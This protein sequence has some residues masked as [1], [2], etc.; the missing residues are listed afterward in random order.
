MADQPNVEQ[1]PNAAP[2]A[3]ANAGV[4]PPLSA[5]PIASLDS[6][7]DEPA[8]APAP[9]EVQQ[10]AP[11]VPEPTPEP[12]A[13]VADA[14]TDEPA[15]EPE[16]TPEPTARVLP[17]RISTQQFSE[18]EQ[19][20]IALGKALKEAGEDVPSLKERIEIVE[21]RNKAKAQ[22]EA[23]P[24]PPPKP[25]EP[26]AVDTLTAEL[27]EL[28]AKLAEAGEKESPLTPELVE[29][30]GKRS[31]VAADLALAKERQANVEAAA[32]QGF[33]AQRAAA[34]AKAKALFP[35]LSDKSSELRLRVN[36]EIAARQNPAH[37]DHE[38]LFVAKS[39]LIITQDVA[40]A[41]AEELAEANGTSVAE[42]LAALM[43]KPAAR[44]AAPAATPKP[45]V[46]TPQTKKVTPASGAAAQA[47]APPAP[48]PAALLRKPFD[49]KA[50]DDDFE[51]VWG[52]KKFM[53]GR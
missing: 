49:P 23:M 8:P 42:E 27:A 15:A 38:S 50:Y 53:L 7:F 26:S 32:R 9:S 41:L 20:A 36:K 4:L 52:P 18:T 30:I 40:T 31:T 22:A 12:E 33:E 10:P 14:P 45:A 21:G 1:A 25:P 43:P 48:D 44:T 13:P 51:N 11:T 5:T 16:P 24:P 28:D 17:N 39:P 47:P 3:P 35:S 34:D 19:E 29:T 46:A 2:E 37:P 6:I